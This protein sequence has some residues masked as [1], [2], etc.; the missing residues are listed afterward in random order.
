MTLGSHSFGNFLDEAAAVSVES[1][2]CLL[3]SR[4]LSP[5]IAC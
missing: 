5:R 4:T 3:S 2:E 1:V